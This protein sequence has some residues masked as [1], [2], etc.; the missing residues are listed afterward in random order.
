MKQTHHLS[1]AKTRDHREALEAFEDIGHVT[2]DGDI[3]YVSFLANDGTLIQSAFPPQLIAALTASLVATRL[4]AG[5]VA[6]NAP[7][8]K[9]PKRK[10]TGYN[11]F[12]AMCLRRYSEEDS[13][14]SRK[15]RMRGAIAQYQALSREERARLKRE[16]EPDPAFK[17][18]HTAPD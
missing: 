1:G 2:V 17:I 14:L 13:P 7:E 11:R 3:A 4:L 15:E 18:V 10:K 16:T 6:G 5:I 9:T 12:L 8:T